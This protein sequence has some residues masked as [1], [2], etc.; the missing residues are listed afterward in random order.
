MNL[1][2]RFVDGSQIMF[3]DVKNVEEDDNDLQFN[4][5]DAD[6]GRV[7]ICIRRSSI[8]FAIKLKGED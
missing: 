3:Q 1:R 5:M 4:Y 7:T 6:L 8:I 2:I